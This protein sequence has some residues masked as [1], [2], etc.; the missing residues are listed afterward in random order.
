MQVYLIR[1]PGTLD[2]PCTNV[3]CGHWYCRV[4]R[5]ILESGKCVVCGDWIGVGQE[6]VRR[7]REYVHLSCAAPVCRYCNKPVLD[8]DQGVSFGKA[9]H[10]KCAAGAISLLR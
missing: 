2:G 4:E 9:V 10:K 1:E 8:R 6:F 3:P 5:E 7:D